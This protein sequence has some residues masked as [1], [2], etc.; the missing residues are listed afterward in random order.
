MESNHGLVVKSHLI[1]HWPISAM[2]PQKES[3]LHH[4]V[5]SQLIYHWPIRAVCDMEDLNPPELIGSQPYYLYMN[6]AMRSLM[7]SNHPV[8]IWSR[9]QSLIKD[10]CW[11]AG[12]RTQINWLTASRNTF[13][14][15]PNNS[16]TIRESNSCPL[17]VKQMRFHYANRACGLYG[18]W[19]HDPSPDK[20]SLCHWAKSPMWR[21]WD[22][23]P[24]LLSESE[25][26]YPWSITP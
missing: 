1:Y 7:D 17:R 16:Y 10:Q 8:K 11:D 3:N 25:L 12:N 20:R 5:K 22:S 23:N 6:I 21:Y 24:V 19:T 2:C 26:T 18:N 13:I 15:H 9:D 4:L 14:P